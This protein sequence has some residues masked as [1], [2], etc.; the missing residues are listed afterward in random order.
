MV[1][2]DS[3]YCDIGSLKNGKYQNINKS[4]TSSEL[5]NE[6]EGGGDQSKEELGCLQFESRFESGN[7]A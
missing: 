4:E 5:I 1:N 7:L 2:F 6:V 3:V